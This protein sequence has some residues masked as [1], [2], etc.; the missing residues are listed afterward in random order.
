MA[1]ISLKTAARLFLRLAPAIYQ[2]SHFTQLTKYGKGLIGC[3]SKV[4]ATIHPRGHKRSQNIIYS[5]VDLIYICLCRC[6]QF[7][8]K[9]ETNRCKN[10]MQ[11]RDSCWKSPLTR[12][13]NKILLR[14]IK[15][16]C[17]RTILCALTIQKWDFL[18]GVSC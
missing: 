8:N 17:Y 14:F 7:N 11:G 15:R 10:C 12:K 9:K 3:A 5:L 4:T 16:H 1:S 2:E 13:N 18:E 6:S